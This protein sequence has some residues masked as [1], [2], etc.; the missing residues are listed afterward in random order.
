MALPVDAD[1]YVRAETDLTLAGLAGLAGGV[2]RWHHT[3]EPAPRDRQPVVRLNRD[4][5]YSFCVV[6]VSEGV[7]VTVPDTGGRYASAMVIDQDHHIEH[8]F[9]APGVHRL[10]PLHVPTSYA[11]LA[12]RIRVDADDPAD[13][14]VVTA[15]QD[16]FGVDAASA[17]PFIPPPYDPASLDAVRRAV[18]ALSAQIDD[19]R[20]AFG[21]RAA[22]NPLRHMLGTALAWGG[23]PEHEALF[24]DV[25]PHLPVGDHTLT[26][27]DVPVDGFWS[28]TVY[29]ADGFLP[30]SG[31]CTV[32]GDTA[33]TDP[34]GAVTVRFGPGA[35]HPNR[36]VAGDGWNYVLRLYRPRPAAVDG[37]WRPPAI[38]PA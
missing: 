33:V 26:L 35:D 7:A 21:S 3:R 22:T 1:N 23:M 37:T 18:L 16:R 24:L 28:L 15:L 32:F 11:L 6:D 5:L 36:L 38:T 12:V 29:T 19:T 17:V 20:G 25:D 34:D 8:V 14:A 13:V 2:N 9:H 31:R 27:R 4:T 30:A 10:T